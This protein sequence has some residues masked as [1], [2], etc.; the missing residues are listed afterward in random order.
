MKVQLMWNAEADKRV[1][2]FRKGAGTRKEPV[3]VKTTTSTIG[4]G[5]NTLPGSC[6]FY[7]A[8]VDEFNNRTSAYSNAINIQKLTKSAP[9]NFRMTYRS[10]TSIQFSW[11]GTTGDK[12]AIYRKISGTND[13][14]VKL[15]ETTN[16][17]MSVETLLGKCEFKV[18]VVSSDED[19]IRLSPFS[20]VVTIDSYQG[21]PAN[22]KLDDS[23]SSTAKF[24]WD[25]AAANRYA[26]YRVRPG[27][28]DTPVK[29]AETRETSL[30][31]YTT[32]GTY[33]YQVAIVD[34]E[35]NRISSFSNIVPVTK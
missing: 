24:S 16:K 27:T 2:I 1:G 32:S 33:D 10:G 15:D 6:D 20:N 26:V 17:Q 28:L 4:E 25:E 3:W 29:V 14:F 13:E 22:F 30:R 11:S 19:G 23:T 21:A 35:G 9:A 8:Y 12:F 31:V 7:V 18:A 34:L 5:V